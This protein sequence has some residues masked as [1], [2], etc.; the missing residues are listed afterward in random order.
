MNH[1]AKLLKSHSAAELIFISCWMLV[2]FFGLGITG[3]SSLRMPAPERM[4]G[5]V[6][7]ATVCNVNLCGSLDHID[8]VGIGSKP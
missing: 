1:I 5:A 3:L 8:D 2:L 7:G 6:A 4:A